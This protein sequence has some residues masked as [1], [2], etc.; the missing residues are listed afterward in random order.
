MGDQCLS[1]ILGV[2][3]EN[4]FRLLVEDHCDAPSNWQSCRDTSKS[5]FHPFKTLSGYRQCLH[6]AGEKDSAAIRSPS[7]SPASSSHSHATTASGTT[8]RPAATTTPLIALR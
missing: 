6:N 2:T 4:D 3:R 1:K 8:A 7:P 5:A